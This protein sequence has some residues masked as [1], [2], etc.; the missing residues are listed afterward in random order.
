MALFDHTGSIEIDAKPSDIRHIVEAIEKLVEY[1]GGTSEQRGPREIEFSI[2]PFTFVGRARHLARLSG[3]R[4]WLDEHSAEKAG[5]NFQVGL[6]KPNKIACI[7]MVVLVAVTAIL[8]FANGG[9]EMGFIPPLL[10]AGAGPLF[11]YTVI[12]QAF[13][14]FERELRDACMLAAKYGNEAQN[15]P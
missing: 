1:N 10:V 15:L 4:I 14:R 12:Q 8:L 3:G 6:S 7:L 13:T 11:S 9:D 5:I 2:P